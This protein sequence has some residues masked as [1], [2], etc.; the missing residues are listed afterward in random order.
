MKLGTQNTFLNK[1]DYQQYDRETTYGLNLVNFGFRNYNPTIGRFLG[2]DLLGDLNEMVSPA[3][4]TNNSFINAVDIDGLYNES[5]G[6]QDGGG[7]VPGA[8]EAEKYQGKPK[9][10]IVT[11]EGNYAGLRAFS[12]MAQGVANGLG[13]L[14]HDLAPIRMIPKSEE[15]T[16]SESIK[17]LKNIPSNLYNLPSQLRKVYSNGSTEQ[18]AQATVQFAG[19]ILAMLKGKA[20]GSGLMMSKLGAGSSTF[21]KLIVH[22]N[23]LKS[24]KPTWGYKLYSQTGKFLKNGITSKVNSQ[25]RYSKSFM[26]DKLMV[27]VE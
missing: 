23:S 7:R 12:D 22:G 3:A 18:K 4:Y 9:E 11:A 19:T 20:Q 8:P 2:A 10:T 14:A 16:F 1:A 27:E 13:Q 26:L 17:D 6:M 5:G 21:S 24:L 25:K 15:S